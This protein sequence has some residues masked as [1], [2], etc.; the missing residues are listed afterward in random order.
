MGAV[1]DVHHGD[2]QNLGVRAAQV[3]VQG[4]VQLGRRSLG[5]RRE[6]PRMALAPSWLC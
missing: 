3:A 1:D 4:L 6:T 5:K 2:G